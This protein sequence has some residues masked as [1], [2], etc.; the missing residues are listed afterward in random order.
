MAI[1][2]DLLGGGLGLSRRRSFG[3]GMWNRGH[4]RSRGF[5]SRGYGRAQAPGYFGGSLGRMAMGGVAAY[6]TRSLLS[7]RYH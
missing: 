4:G 6:L 5:S 7:R 1:L 3:G 2:G